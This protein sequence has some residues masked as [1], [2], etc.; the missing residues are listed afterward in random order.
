[1]KGL[2]TIAEASSFASQLIGKVVT[3]S[4]ISYLIQYGRI[5]KLERNGVV[6]VR[7]EQ[8]ISY[9]ESF[10]GKKEIE[11]KNKLGDDINWELS[12]DGYKES[13][14]TK[15]VHRLH[16]YKGKYI[17]QLV[18]YF[19]DEHIDSFKKEVYFQ[20]GDIVIDPFCGSGTTLVQANE[21]GIHAVGFD[22]SAYNAQI[23]NAKIRRYDIALLKKYV[24]R[25]TVRLEEFEAELNVFAFEKELLEELYKFN[26]QYFPS[27][28][29][30]KKVYTKQINEKE[31][32]VEKEREFLPNFIRLA[33]KHKIS[34]DITNE[35]FLE[36][37][38]FET[39]RKEI[40]F[41]NSLIE[42]V[43]NNEL[44]E[45]LQ[46][47]LSRT[48]RSCRATTH[49]DLATLIEPVYT[50]YYCTK[51]KKICKPLFSILKWWKTYSKDTIK[52]IEQFSTL[53][54]NTMQKCFAENSA[55]VDIEQC[56]LGMG[57]AIASTYGDKK[58]KGIFCSPPYVGL[59]DYHEQ[60]AYAYELY[61]L[62][63][64][65]D[66]EIGSMQKGNSKLAQQAYVESISSVLLN[67]KK[68]LTEDYEVFIV[69]NDKFG[70][71]QEIAERA[72]MMI[73][74]QFKRPVLNRT[75]KDKNAYSEIIFRM[76]ERK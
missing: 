50:T 46:V 57:G 76:K 25:I 17:P 70:L 67:C 69:A 26:T 74:E 44:K 15:H 12:F 32:G 22:I 2:L 3:E 68:Y 14:T 48:M 64:H 72:G 23:S 20:H 41:V 66:L 51:H 39:A 24:D 33:K 31:Y 11:W 42:K 27:P 49:S 8:L 19:L 9:Y 21:L 29:F 5:D 56:I 52:R 13:E 16:P 45:L 36:R 62:D 18:E 38:Y 37:W 7:Q 65:D 6:C 55:T 4:N 34:L 43:E 75:E 30:K 61:G 59:I 10:K 1:M 54:T 60:H 35:S 58:I 71:Y 53:N 28:D 40:Y 73:V 63:R 47:I